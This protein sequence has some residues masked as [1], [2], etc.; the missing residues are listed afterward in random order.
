M[1][2]PP[3][4]QLL[5][6][7]ASTATPKM[8][9]TA[10]P[11]IYKRGGRYVVVYRDPSGRQRKRFAQTFKEAR[12]LKNELGADVSR[13]EHRELSTVTFTDYAR[14]WVRTYT[15]RTRR[16]IGES[17]KADYA[18]ALDH[19]AIPFFG[20]ARL[21]AIEPRDVKRFTLQLEER[22]L[23]SASVAKNA[24]P[25]RAL[26]ATAVEEGL[27]RSN[28]AAGLRIAR[29][30]D[31]D[32]DERARALTAEQVD[33]LLDAAPAESRLFLRF[34]FETGVR[35]GEAI[36]A[37]FRDVDFGERW[38]TV[39]RQYARG[40]VKP[41]K[42]RKRRRVKLDAQLARELWR[43]RGERRASDGD[44]LFPATRGGRLIPSNLMSRMLKPAAVSAGFGRWIGEGKERR[45][46]SWVGFHTLRH[47]CATVLFRS[48]WNAKQVQRFLG[49]ADPGFTL[50]TYVHL[51]DEDM[52][53]VPFGA[54]ALGN[55]RATRAAENGRESAAGDPAGFV[56]YAGE[57]SDEPRAAEVAV[58][59]S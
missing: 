53:E 14:E 54:L 22:G 6:R 40:K 23:A 55:E 30:S 4:E 10:T 59:N 28:P 52:P 1:A 9:K 46:E 3:T 17:T 37:R 36:E 16:G 34:L 2:R 7:K 27:I 5:E 31:E 35:I 20:R 29:S 41:P 13:G 18:D 33:A 11:G 8:E 48:G 43:L 21:A 49:H 45:A 44:L 12:R 19:Y 47:S 42:G 25:V 39:E 56:V 57:P 26:F 24:A 50:R 51:L 38:L 15:G 58:A 32:H